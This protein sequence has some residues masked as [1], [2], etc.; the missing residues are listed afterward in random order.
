MLLRRSLQVLALLVLAGTALSSIGPA[1]LPDDKSV[2]LRRYLGRFLAWPYEAAIERPYTIEVPA[3]TDAAVAA[4]LEAQADKTKARLE[5]LYPDPANRESHPPVG[6][7][8]LK[9][10]PW[11]MGWVYGRVLQ[12]EVRKNVTE[13]MMPVVR[14]LAWP[15]QLNRAFRTV[16]PFIADDYAAEMAGIAAGSGVALPLLKQMHAVPEISE[17]MC[18]G[19]AFDAGVMADG[20]SY[21]VR[22]LDYATYLKVQAYP[23]VVFYQPLDEDGNEVGNAYV[24]VAWAGFHWSVGG[25]NER[26]L[27]IGEIGGGRP[28]QVA[29]E[30]PDGEPMGV[31]LRRVLN[32]A[33]DVREAESIVAAARRNLRYV[34]VV[35]DARE[36]EIILSGPELYRVNPAGET[37]PKLGPRYDELPGF[38][39]IAWHGANHETHHVA[40]FSEKSAQ[41]TLDDI[42]EHN[43]AVALK[44]SLHAWVLTRGGCDGERCA[45]LELRVAN[46]VDTYERAVDQPYVW[47]DLNRHFDELREM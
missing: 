14:M 37:L 3:L 12:D 13:N 1:G 44:K 11:E 19:M 17:Q 35:S 46:A 9:G 25:V 47:L 6:V 22:L 39:G 26:G 45:T 34:Y 33:S 16:E 18:S 5:W 36:Q 15:R 30:R 2:V 21:H 8:L 27:A 32:G 10:R 42:L 23:L 38:D 29:G 24:N 43:K 4:R 7:L 28:D 40:R 41:L 20:L 31:L